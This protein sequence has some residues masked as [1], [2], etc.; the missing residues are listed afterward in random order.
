MSCEVEGQVKVDKSATRQ[1]ANKLGAS[2]LRHVQCKLLWAQSQVKNGVL[3]LKQI[4]TMWNPADLGT[5]GLN[6][7]RHNML[8]YLFG[9]V[10]EKGEWVGELEYQDS[11]YLFG[12]FLGDPSYDICS[13]KHFGSRVDILIGYQFSFWLCILV[14]TSNQS[15]DMFLKIFWFVRSHMTVSAF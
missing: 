13:P 4:P 9:F 6:R 7:R 5:K 3:T 12:L 1:I 2:K 14:F 10:D 8:L 15:H 11:P